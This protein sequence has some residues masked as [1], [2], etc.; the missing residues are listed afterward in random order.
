MK[1]IIIIG[2]LLIFCGKANTQ[3]A[4]YL[5]LQ[6]T[7]L[8]LGIRSDYYIKDLG[9]YS[10]LSY[11]NGYIY[12][13]RNL[14]HHIKLSTGILIPLPNYRGNMYDIT[15]GINYHYEES[16]TIHYP[17]IETNDFNPLSYELGITVKFKCFTF[18]VRT[19]IPR[20]ET[21][22]DIGILFKSR[23]NKLKKL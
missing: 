14:K 22:F 1:T 23:D 9:F 21:Y 10:S 20:F 7:D 5:T 19:D 8:G 2:L 6:P 15:A 11:G 13:K 4:I 17:S 12:R 16:L 3:N 18:A